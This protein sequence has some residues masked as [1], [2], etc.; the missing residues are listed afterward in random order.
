MKT[1]TTRTVPPPQAAPHDI[2]SLLGEYAALSQHPGEED[3]RLALAI[4]VCE[5][6]QLDEAQNVMPTR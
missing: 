3:E 6:L 4:R 2:A 5:V 1:T